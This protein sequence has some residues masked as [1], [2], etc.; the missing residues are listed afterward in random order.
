M[1]SLP[2]LSLGL[3]SLWTAGKV[4]NCLPV[5]VRKGVGA[6]AKSNDREKHGILLFII[7][8][9]PNKVDHQDFFSAVG[10]GSTPSPRAGQ[11]K[12]ILYLPHREKKEQ[13]R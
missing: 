2:S 10:L 4:P 13:E 11:Y 7:V 8:P 5:L 9:V 6:G 12:Q 1:G 3:S